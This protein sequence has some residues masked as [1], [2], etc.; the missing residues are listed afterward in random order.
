MAVLAQ[1][2]QKAQVNASIFPLLGFQET[3]AQSRAFQLVFSGQFTNVPPPNLAGYFQSRPKPSLNFR[4]DLC[5][6]LAIAVLQT[7][8]L[9]LVHKNIRPGNILYARQV[10]QHTTT[11]KNMVTLQ[12]KINQHPERQVPT[13]E[14]EYTMA[15]DVYSLGESLIRP[16]PTPTV[17]DAFVDAFDVLKFAPNQQDPADRHSKFPKNNKAVLLAMNEAHIPIEAGTKMCHTVRDFLKCLDKGEDEYLPANEKDRREVAK[18][19]VDTALT[20][21]RNVRHAI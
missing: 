19:F 20:D 3:S 4:V 13:A 7:H 12:H 5:Y 9:E 16:G 10:E 11:F 6:Q 18:Q 21:L 1:K 15:H 14:H 17:S 8:A 2:L